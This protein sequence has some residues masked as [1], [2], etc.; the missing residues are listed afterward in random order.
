MHSGDGFLKCVY[1]FFFALRGSHDWNKA[2]PCLVDGG[3][4]LAIGCG[5]SSGKPRWE[6]GTD[7]S[8]VGRR[9][10][11]YPASRP[12]SRRQQTQPRVR[13]RSKVHGA[14]TSGWDRQKTNA[15]KKTR[16]KYQKKN[17]KLIICKF[18]QKERFYRSL[19]AFKGGC[20]CVGFFFLS[21][22]AEKKKQFSRLK[23]RRQ[24]FPSCGRDGC[25]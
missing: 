8:A 22:C 11:A 3:H 19:L 15:K 7:L 5:G 14:G 4:M 18:K 2:A 1:L 13:E 20:F 24:T 10:P 23:L 9:C 16:Q 21:Y 6:A 12:R 25:I 17:W